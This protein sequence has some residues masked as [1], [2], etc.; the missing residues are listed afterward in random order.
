ELLAQA[1]PPELL[2]P[3]RKFP[4][5][6]RIRK[7][8]ENLFAS[9]SLKYKFNESCNQRW[10]LVEGLAGLKCGVPRALHHGADIETQQRS[11]QRAHRR[12]DA[13]T[14]TDVR[15]DLENGIVFLAR[16]RPEISR[17]RIRRR[18]K[19]L[20]RFAGADR[21]DHPLTDDRERRHGFGSNA[22]FCDDIDQCLPGVDRLKRIVNEV[23]I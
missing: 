16:D 6:L 9:L 19:T 5:R 3:E 13:E 7:E 4:E 21:I 10:I 12:E 23:R 18:N 2:E 1:F 22:G 14:S 20:C 15:R 11:R 17:S 8:N